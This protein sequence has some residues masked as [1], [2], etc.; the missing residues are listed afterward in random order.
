MDGTLGRV[1]LA[2]AGLCAGTWLGTLSHVRGVAM[3][4]VV[5]GAALTL[6]RR[7]AGLALVAI[8]LVVAGAG[9]LNAQVRMAPR[10]PLGDIAHDVPRCTFEGTIL[11]SIGG[12]GTLVDVGAIECDSFTARSVGV[13]S[14]PDEVGE[15]GARFTAQ[16]WVVPL[17]SDG[18]ETTLRRAG[19]QASLHISELEVVRSPR[20]A[21]AIAA[22]VREGLN[23]AVSDVDPR[24][25]AL[26]KGL[27][28]GDTS[29]LGSATIDIF[30][31]AGLSH[32]LAV[33]G[34]NVAIVLGAVMVGLRSIGHRVRIGFG[35]LGLGLFVLVVGPDASVLRAAAMGAIALACLAQGRTAEPLAALG[36]AVIA[37]V[38]LRP[39]M[40]FSVGMQLSAAATAGI[41]LFSGPISARLAVLPEAF[42]TMIAATLA[43]QIAVAPLLILVFGELSL[44]AP[45]ANALALPAVAPGTVAGLASGIV[46]IPLPWLGASLIR[47][48]APAASW[49]LFVADRFGS[50][51]WSL[52]RVPTVVGW[53]L[54]GLVA[55]WA[56]R[57]LRAS[58]HA[59]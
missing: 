28:I 45:F 44:V 17:G 49:I 26:I 12:L 6:V 30:R 3:T 55:L 34:S 1:W 14:I 18:F 10:G 37:V 4:M 38:A 56:T 41:V 54:M 57:V 23:T 35:Y 51:E 53:P 52:A 27:T 33:S 13:A 19:A 50:L 7:R 40:L 31:N 21:Q 24:A 5:A 39:G 16:G 48:V 46:A 36:L 43:A 58:D 11:E 32:I 29:G 59:R 25:G 22:R 20:G 8:V 47:L 2:T 42:R 9:M 15:P